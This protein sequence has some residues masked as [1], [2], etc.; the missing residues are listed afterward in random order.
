MLHTMISATPMSTP[1]E[2]SAH[3]PAADEGPGFESNGP[4]FE[5]VMAGYKVTEQKTKLN[6]ILLG[7]GPGSQ[8]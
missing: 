8:S 6:R 1:A 4:G 7:I 3:N 5:S 2:H